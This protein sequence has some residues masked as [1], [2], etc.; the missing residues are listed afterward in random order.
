MSDDDNVIH[1][2]FGAPGEVTEVPEDPA[3]QEKLHVFST[4][5]DA[6]T[7]MVTLDS[8]VSGVTVPAAHSD[9]MQLNLNFCHQYGIPDFS[10]D[11]A[12]LRASLSFGGVNT[13]CD[14]PW[15]AVYMMR[16]HESGEAVAFPTSIPEEIRALIPQFQAM[17]EEE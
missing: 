13:F 6:G 1:V 14:I 4:M 10:Y 3:S 16:S 5:V 15:A 17:Y 8:R 7:V 11:E 2:Q 9:Q 12:G